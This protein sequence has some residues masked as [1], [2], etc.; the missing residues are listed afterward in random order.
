MV[1]I[2]QLI[3][4]LTKPSGLWYI[5]FNYIDSFTF[6]FGW[7]IILFTLFIKLVLSPLDFY[8]RY[9]TKKNTLIQ[10]KLAPQVEKINKTFANDKNKANQQ[11]NILYKREGYN[12]IGSCIFMLLNLVL[13]LVIFFTIYSSLRTTSNYKMLDQYITLESVYDSTDG[14]EEEKKEAVIVKYN[15]IKD[16]WLWIKNI[17]RPDS[18][19]SPIP[20]YN[21]FNK[22]LKNTK[23]YYNYAQENITEEKYN[24][25]MGNLIT[26]NSKTWNGYFI[27][28]ILAA[29]T[30]FL[31]QFVIELGNKVK[32]EKQINNKFNDPQLATKSAMN[33]MKFVMPIIM[34]IFVITNTASFGIYIVISSIIS[35]LLSVIINSIVKK[36]TYKQEEEYIEQLEK[37]NLK[38][39]KKRQI[40]Y[41]RPSIKPGA[42]L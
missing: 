2:T 12:M 4:E 15:E 13:T 5:I 35:S 6:N 38:I 1:Y 36:L 40:N 29:V 10:K 3:S 7:T 24:A 25:V 33:I 34:V 41:E 30:S 9:S 23:I 27:L 39:A 21:D 17:W 11:V 26:S 42:K 28:A 37:N 32:K 14:S 19:V 20:S 22:S 18:N 8:N 31:S 16:D